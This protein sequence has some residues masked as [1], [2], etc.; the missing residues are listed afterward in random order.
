ML[1]I[2][3]SWDSLQISELKWISRH[4]DEVI[5][6]GDRRAIIIK[7]PDDDLLEELDARSIGYKIIC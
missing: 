1:M 5:V 3:I 2:A 4:S 7:N 6:D